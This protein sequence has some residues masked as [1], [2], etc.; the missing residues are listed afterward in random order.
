MIEH[1]YCYGTYRIFTF[2]GAVIA[3][4]FL[5]ALRLIWGGLF[6]YAGYHKIMNLQETVDYFTT[7]HLPYP[8]LNAYLVAFFEVVGGIAIVI[9]F[10]TRFFAI[11]LLII[12]GVALATAHVSGFDNV[13]HALAQPPI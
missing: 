13:E 9:G 10:A 3:P 11:P 6:I 1:Q 12:M 2:L 7:L 5:L 8:V 4:F